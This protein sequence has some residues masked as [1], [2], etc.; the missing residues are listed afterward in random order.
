MLRIIK[1]NQRGCINPCRT[2]TVITTVI[3]ILQGYY[4]QQDKN[5]QITFKMAKL[6][7]CYSPS[8]VLK[9]QKA[10]ALMEGWSRSLIRARRGG[11][12]SEGCNY[13]A[14]YEPRLIS[15][16]SV[17]ANAPSSPARARRDQDRRVHVT[18]P[19]MKTRSGNAQKHRW[20]PPSS[21]CVCV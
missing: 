12:A 3:T 21:V 14:G 9:Q 5:H 1:I 13:T 18:A 6:L 16:V 19:P 8:A 11:Y 7:A 15:H 17:A 4:T 10:A 20:E 2:N